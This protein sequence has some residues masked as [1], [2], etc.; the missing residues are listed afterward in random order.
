MNSWPALAGLLLALA[1]CATPPAPPP[2]TAALGLAL[3][4][5][6][7]ASALV[8]EGSVLRHGASGMVFPVEVAGFRRGMPHV[9]DAV[10]LDVSSGYTLAALRGPVVATVYV[11]PAPANAAGTAALE[12]LF[13][14]YK[15]EVAASHGGAKP[16]AEAS[17]PPPPG[18]G[19]AEGRHARFAYADMFA[20]ARRALRSELF[21]FCCIAPGWALEYRFTY[22]QDSGQEDTVEQFMRGLRVTVPSGS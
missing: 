16:V 10:G 13:A 22:T 6:A 7:V 11:F 14:K 15:A 20:G 18:A 9:Y 19:G 5:A 8:A 12:A 1:G 21:V 3:R 2:G 17:A 4:Q